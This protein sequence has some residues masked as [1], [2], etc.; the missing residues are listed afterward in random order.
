M[1]ELD[2]ATLATL[3]D[4]ALAR[5]LQM[6]VADF[7]DVAATIARSPHST[8]EPAQRASADAMGR[9]ALLDLGAARSAHG[10]ASGLDLEQTIGEGGMGIVRLATQRSLGRKVAV[11]TLRPAARNDAA[12]LRLLREAWVTGTLEHPNI[13]PVY[14]LGACRT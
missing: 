7:A 6:N 11:K 1:D 8:I 14:D 2:P 4:D 3:S 12:T 5:T 9:R 13:V 10:I